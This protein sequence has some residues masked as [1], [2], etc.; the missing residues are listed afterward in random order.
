LTVQRQDQ[1]EI[2]GDGLPSSIRYSRAARVGEDPFA[3]SFPAAGSLVTASSVWVRVL[4]TEVA[5]VEIVSGV[6]AGIEDA[7]DWVAGLAQSR[8]KTESF[9]IALAAAEVVRDRQMDCC[10]A[11]EV[12][13]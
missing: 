6:E 2:P 7:E 12:V 8:D 11:M 5:R 10:Y 4:E 1:E 3:G 9:D 13:V